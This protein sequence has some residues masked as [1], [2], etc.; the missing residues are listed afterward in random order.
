MI[1]ART[2]LAAATVAA[3]IIGIPALANAQS[4][5]ARNVDQYTCK[6]VMQGTDDGRTTAIAFLHGF[7]LG[8]SGG[9]SFDLEAMAKQ[10]DSFTD[11]CLDNP[12]E[13][14]ITAMMKFK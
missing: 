11:Y 12:K 13:K 6:D 9:S 8:K 10:T 7:L 2:I 3:A 1:E 4:S 14:A 5:N